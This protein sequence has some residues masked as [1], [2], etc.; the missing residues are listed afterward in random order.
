MKISLNEIKKYVQI[1]DNISTKDLIT[2]IIIADRSYRCAHS[3]SCHHI[4]C[5]LGCLFDIVAG[6]GGYVVKYYLLCDSASQQ[7]RYILKHLASTWG[8]PQMSPTDK[9]KQVR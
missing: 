5:R 2:L 9:K 7:N 4:L 6:S 1:P 3:V 8:I